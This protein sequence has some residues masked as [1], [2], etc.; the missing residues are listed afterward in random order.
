MKYEIAPEG[1]TSHD[2]NPFK[3]DGKYDRKYSSLF[4]SGVQNAHIMNGTSRSGIFHVIFNTQVR[5][6]NQRIIDFITYENGFGRTVIVGSDHIDDL[7]E[8]MAS[9]EGES[10]PCLPRAN[11][12]RILV[13]ST[14]RE[15]WDSISSDGMMKSALQLTKE[16]K[17][18]ISI[19]Y[20]EL[21]EPEEYRDFIMF[22]S[23]G[24]TTEFIVLSQQKGRIV[25]DENALYRPGVR[26][27]FD[28]R[29]M[30]HDGMVFRD[31]LHLIKVKTTLD[32][33]KYMLIA[34]KPEDLE[35][36]GEI[37][38]TPRLFAERSDELFLGKCDEYR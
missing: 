23:F 29:K 14:S 28:C 1:W 30:V 36:E 5:D 24:F 37:Q 2:S 17:H 10:D 32:L 9:L 22:G 3:A 34:V 25:T 21:Q 8:F 6:R 15:A 20:K 26:I 4:L 12:P 11:D 35:P 19:G 38:W 31:G 13:H 7:A 33:A 16:K 27:Y 18:F